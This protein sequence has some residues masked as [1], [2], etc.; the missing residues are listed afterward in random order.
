MGFLGWLRSWWDGRTRGKFQRQPVR[1]VMYTRRG[2]HL[3]ED[4]WQVLQ[5]EQRRHG[6]HLEAV[7]VDADPELAARYGLCV[8]VV[9]VAGEV[10][11]RGRVNRVLLARLLRRHR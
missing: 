10:R 2:C 8:P 5:Q 6:F 3:C 9:T 1:L 4:A 11:F 7:D